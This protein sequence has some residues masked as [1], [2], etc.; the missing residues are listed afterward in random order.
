MGRKANSRKATAI[1]SD[2]YIMYFVSFIQSITVKGKHD[3]HTSINVES[4]SAYNNYLLLN[5]S[6]QNILAIIVPRI[7]KFCEL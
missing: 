3:F 5:R 1:Y 2:L 4:Q 7:Y 6:Y